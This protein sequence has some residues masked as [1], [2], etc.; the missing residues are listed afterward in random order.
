MSANAE[1]ETPLTKSAAALFIPS[2]EVPEVLNLKELTVLNLLER[3][4]QD[5]NFS[6]CLNLK[7]IKEICERTQEEVTLLLELSKS[8]KIDGLEILNKFNNNFRFFF[9]LIILLENL[10]KAKLEKKELE[11]FKNLTLSGFLNKDENVTVD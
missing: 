6:E 5:N 3:I 1:P 8:V 2:Q 4:S 9:D 10:K 7:K 11:K